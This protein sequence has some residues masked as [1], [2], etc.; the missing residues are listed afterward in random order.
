[1]T[2]IDYSLVVN[3]FVNMYEKNTAEALLWADKNIDPSMFE[4]LKPLIRQELIDRG[5]TFNDVS[6]S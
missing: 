6:N 1:M 3:R 4:P 5:W 2:N